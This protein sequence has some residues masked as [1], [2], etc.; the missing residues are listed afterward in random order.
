M[1]ALARLR[2]EVTV[3]LRI[4][5]AS[6]STPSRSPIDCPQH[7]LLLALHEDGYAP[8]EIANI[9]VGAGWLT[10]TG[11]E[12][13]PKRVWG[14]LQKIR[15]RASRERQMVITYQSAHLGWSKV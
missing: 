6:L 13:T 11:L 10:A 8:I 2:L 1:D 5:T 15:R 4:E 3:V 7:Q 9:L 14:V 12:Y